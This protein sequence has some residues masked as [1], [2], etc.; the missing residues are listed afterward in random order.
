MQGNSLKNNLVV[1]LTFI[2]VLP[3]AVFAYLCANIVDTYEVKLD[4]SQKNKRQ[5][6]NSI[7]E[8]QLEKL[9][10]ANYSISHF[11][12]T[13][14]I[15]QSRH[16][17]D[18]SLTAFFNKIQLTGKQLDHNLNILITNEKQQNI[19]ATSPIVLPKSNLLNCDKDN[20]YILTKDN[21]IGSCSTIRLNASTEPGSSFQ[22][23][24]FIEKSDLF[25]NFSDIK[26][27]SSTGVFSKKDLLIET[28]SVEKPKWIWLIC[29]IGFMLIVSMYFGVAIFKK[30]ILQP[31][32][33]VTKY[34]AKNNDI[35][36][37]EDNEI[38][39][40]MEA[41]DYYVDEREKSLKNLMR[42]RTLADIGRS[43]QMITHDIKRP[44]SL[45]QSVISALQKITDPKVF[46]KQSALYLSRMASDMIFV[47]RMINNVLTTSKLSMNFENCVIEE[48]IIGSMNFNARGRPELAQVE[49]EWDL[50]HKH[51]LLTDKIKFRRILDNIFSN[52]FDIIKSN[53]K[54]KIKTIDNGSFTDISISNTGKGITE[55]EREQLFLPT[56]TK[57]KKHG[58]GLGL[59]IVSN[60]VNTLKGS[61]RC[62][63]DGKS[64]TEFIISFPNKSFKAY[65]N[66]CALPSK[67]NELADHGFFRPLTNYQ[68][69]NKR[70]L[71]IVDDD[72][73]IKQ[74][75]E[76]SDISK[77]VNLHIFTDP[78]DLIESL[79]KP[80][81]CPINVRWVIFD[82][83]YK[84]TKI[85]DKGGRVVDLVRTKLERPKVFLSSY[86]D[87]ISFDIVE[88]YFDGFLEKR[89]Y[90]VNELNMVAT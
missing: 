7:A 67:I 30:E 55:S 11:T 25:K 42:E 58:H 21:M 20:H 36:L 46:E 47:E 22:L 18:E 60:I 74:L 53:N 88:K 6:I 57:G 10:F 73:I 14:D 54:I 15:L 49:I 40:I 65:Q 71:V 85:T 27:S 86:D 23:F 90:S 76:Q 78:E 61:I 33:E 35:K 41:F 5:T 66:Y 62:E 64:Y 26:L 45:L 69:V 24:T 9:N 17:R 80:E 43:V 52:C 13:I 72:P 70:S 56:Y 34:I 63:S 16:S 32:E 68:S 82:Y 50:K 1:L 48:L 19:L 77:E 38:I 51:I 3:T 8:S 44:M 29:F 2:I 37:K 4:K 39:R 75:W 89:I 59:F 81:K 83:L 31:L 87:T 79:F 12:E 84:R 28:T